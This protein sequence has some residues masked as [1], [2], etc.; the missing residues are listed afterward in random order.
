[1]G[2]RPFIYNLAVRLGLTGYVTNTSEGVTIE[3]QAA[4][5]RIDRFIESITSE[6]PPLADPRVV[7]VEPMDPDGTEDAFTI[8]HSRDSKERRAVITPD[9]ATC[10][11]CLAELADPADRRYRYPF[12]NC[13]NCG[14]RY[15]IIFDIPYDRPNTTMRVFEMCPRCRAEYED[16][17]NRRFHAQ[18]NACPACGPKVFLVDP[19]GAAVE[20]D[21]AVAE[22]VRR[23]EAGRI[24]AVKGL[25]GFHL[26]ARADRD[27]TVRELRERKYRKA[28]SFAVM[29]RDVEAARRLAEIDATAEK[30]L[31]GVERPIVLCPKKPHGPLS[32]LTA[33]ASRF[34]GIMLPYTPLHTLLMEGDYPA[35]VMTSGN[36]TDEPIEHENR[37]ALERLGPI[38]DVLLMHD[39]DIFTSCDDSVV[40]VFDGAPLMIRRAR[41]YVPR[42]VRL[43]RE[44]DGDILAVGA[45]LKNTICFVKGREAFVS[46]HI[47]DLEGAA[48]YES[49]QRTIEKL[50]ALIDARPR[51]IAC[52]LHPAMLSTRFAESWEGAVLVRVQH[53]HAHIAAVMGEHDLDGPV[54]GLAADGVGY[55]DDGGVWGCEVLAAWR[56]KY[57]R[58]A[59]LEPVPMPGGDAASRE[60]WRMAVSWLA[61][62]FGT[63]EGLALSRRL[64]GAIDPRRLEAVAAM[65]AKKVNSPPTTSLGRLFDAVSALAGVCLENTYEAQAAIELESSVDPSETDGY[66]VEIAGASPRVLSVAPVVRAVVEDLLAGVGA[67]KVA[68]RFHRFAVAA[69]AE[70]ARAAAE[71]IGTETVA[72]AGGVFQNDILLGGLLRELRKRSL[73]A[74][75]NR[76]L[77]PNDGSIAFGQ[78][79]AADALAARGG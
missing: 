55:G 40:K 73:R 11:D 67:P 36:A 8:R 71:A 42:P 57:E 75:F 2:F 18:P 33:P 66:P 47:G 34:W 13:T 53:H 31:T 61:H 46:Q 62:A 58:L 70:L 35:L 23:L 51:A 54:V 59:H 38:A 29:V 1:V 69:L 10:K 7:S 30:L 37:S 6:H 78:A 56:H 9:A 17:S 63:D 4:P 12:I 39:R 50:G 25:G 16:P 76:L 45:Q 43:R 27:E 28:K 15:T 64:I 21:E 3:A 68:A 41:G 77:P 48:T 79:V 74:Y 72:L 26:A 22:T 24:A 19:S 14:P 32:D 52:D 20:C 5:E 49:F 60:P 44:W 65:A